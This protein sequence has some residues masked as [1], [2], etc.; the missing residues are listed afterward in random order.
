[1]KYSNPT[2][3]V[4]YECVHDTFLGRQIR[5][6]GTSSNCSLCDSKRKCVPLAEIVE[7]VN[8]ILGTYI[9]EGEHVWRWSEGRIEYQEGDG[10][11]Y[12]VSEIFGCEDQERIVDAVCRR[13]T[14]YS[15]DI[16]Y[17]RQRFSLNDIGH[18]WCEF[19]EGMKHGIRFF[20]DSA[21]AFLGWIFKDLDKYSASF[22]E[23]AVVRLLT[24]EN[25]PSIFRART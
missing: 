5:R 19:Q 23:N 7:R 15:D 4:C 2:E 25:S 18:Q 13:L 16:Q 14:S 1:M 10:I 8:E 24:P 9:T 6:N 3:V 22:D 12:W 21:K 17:S 20:N 11:D